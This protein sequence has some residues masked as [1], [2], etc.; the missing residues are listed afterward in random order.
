MLS[1]LMPQR[2][3]FYVLLAT[4][5]DRVV[6]GAN[7]TLRLLNGL[8]NNAEDLPTLVAEVSL[9]EQAG[10]KIKAEVITLLHRSFT[11]PINRDQ[12]HSLVIELDGVLNAL[13]D[14]ARAVSM[15]NIKESTAEARELASLAAD[16]SMRLNRAVTG[17]AE[18]GRRPEVIG[19]CKEIEEIEAKAD[20]VQR[21]AITKLF[22]GSSTAWNAVKMSRFY[23][24]QE[25]V[26]DACEEAAKTIEEIL[27]ENS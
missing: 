4:L 24:L 9:L 8:G 27:I 16:A 22:D 18:K 2:K 5:S 12:I 17:L 11:T 26:L 13:E 15:Y 10:D 21:K 6:A 23:A 25:V 1:S 20:V 3:E 14:V 19:F 7:A